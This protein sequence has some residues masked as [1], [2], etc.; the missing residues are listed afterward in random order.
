MQ[1][2]HQDF[3]SN[4]NASLKS[5]DL[6][7][8]SDILANEISDFIVF[9]TSKI[10]DALNKAGVKITSQ[11]SDEEIVDMVMKSLSENLTFKKTFAFIIAEGN[12]LIN[13]KNS[14]A[15][16][17]KQKQMDIINNIASG[18]SKV[19][20]SIVSEPKEFKAETMN[21]I[22]AKAESRKEYKRIIWK[23]NMKNGKVALYWA[24]TGLALAGIVVIVYYRQKRALAKSIP[25]MI[26]GAGGMA[27]T[28]RPDFHNP[29]A[30]VPGSA[31]APA[32]SSAPIAPAANPFMPVQ[33]P[34]QTPVVPIQAAA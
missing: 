28:S 31:P 22:V 21:Q 29:S 7:L 25:N 6:S 3:Y 15:G 32:P 17:D 5:G 12:E 10:I 8:T 14:K 13:N 11:V 1:F 23:K 33:A 34:G 16:N 26:M 18:L 4:F 24:I 27:D 9:D 19:N 30:P 20:S 2:T